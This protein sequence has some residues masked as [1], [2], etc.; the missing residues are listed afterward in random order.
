MCDGENAPLVFPSPKFQLYSVALVLKLEK[1]TAKGTAP[2][3][4]S[5]AKSAITGG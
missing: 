4:V 3:V 1:F 5:A 2:L